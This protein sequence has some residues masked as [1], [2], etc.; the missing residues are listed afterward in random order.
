MPLIFV[1]LGGDQFTIEKVAL[2]VENSTVVVIVNGTGD[3]ANMLAD[4]VH[5]LNEMKIR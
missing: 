1:V 4:M 3:I 5:S 2:A